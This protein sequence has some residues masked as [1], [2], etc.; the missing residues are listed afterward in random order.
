MYNKKFHKSFFIVLGI[1]L[2]IF[3][4]DDLASRLPEGN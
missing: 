2:D 1:S 3:D 4:I